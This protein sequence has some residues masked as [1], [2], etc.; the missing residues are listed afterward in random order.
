MD[1]LNFVF[2]ENSG[3]LVMIIT[4]AIIGISEILKSFNINKK[5]IPL[6]NI[7][8]GI[9]SGLIFF[10][11]CDIRYCVLGGLLIG[12]MASGMYSSIKNIYQGF[13]SNK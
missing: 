12:F 11:D 4:V 13:I 2:G 7:V 5:F 8:L 9:I 10:T 1:F 3:T 6:F